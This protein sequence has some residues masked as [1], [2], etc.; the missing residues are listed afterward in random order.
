MA[1][2]L[3]SFRRGEANL[4]ARSLRA[5]MVDHTKLPVELWGMVISLAS[6]MEQRTSLSV[7]RLFHD[8]AL[9]VVFRELVLPYGPL[10]GVDDNDTT[11]PVFPDE[12][13]KQCSRNQDI[14]KHTSIDPV[15]ARAIRKIDICWFGPHFTSEGLVKQLGNKFRWRLFV[16]SRL[17]CL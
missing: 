11:R 7:S 3:L 8:L 12:L 5:T 13:R 2:D 1:V 15:F 14:L 17:V 10:D 6:R 9:P 16:P 4:S